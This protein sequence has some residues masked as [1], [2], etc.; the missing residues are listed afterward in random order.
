MRDNTP[1]RGPL[2]G[3]RVVEIAGI[4]PGPVC[5][6]LL[7]D[8][9]AEVLL[10]ERPDSGDVGI[11]RARRF[12]VGHRG[13]AS[14][15]MDLRQPQTRDRALELI[16]KAD[17]LIEGFRPGTMERLGLG[18]ADCLAV[19]SRLV[20]GRMTGYGQSGALAMRAG[21]DLN[22]ISLSGALHVIGRAGQAPTPPLNLVGDYA[23]GSMLLAFGIAAAL[24]ER[25]RSGRGQV[26]DASM[27]EG[28]SLLM[29]SFHGMF[30]AGLASRPRGENLL[31][32]GA[33]FYD[34]YVCGDGR[35]VAFGAIERKFRKAFAD[36]T[37]FP[38]ELL[39]QEGR[40]WWP[41]MRAQL[42][43][44]F[45]QRSRD[46]WCSLLEDSDACVT[47][48]L[49]PE[50]VERHRHNSDRRSFYSVQGVLH[51]TP[52][53]RFSRSV[54]RMPGDSPEPGEG[55]VELARAWGVANITG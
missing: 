52:A 50:E 49:A 35:Y 45:L 54:P 9:G 20:Y 6:M 10:I 41:E 1:A 36:I 19:N 33:P 14:L 55:G 23:G 48:V 21:H 28:S 26:I 15:V 22:Y 16:A 3:V 47:P 37:G 42:S 32:S 4:G 46:E 17:V 24:V 5:G 39:L 25:E 30:A 51:P 44:L 40:Q 8:M 27:V 38:A 53:P 31:D 13:K 11:P 18:P 34:V 2:A 43:R 29:A 7:S 12:E